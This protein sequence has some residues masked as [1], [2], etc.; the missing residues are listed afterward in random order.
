[1]DTNAKRDVAELDAR[2][3]AERYSLHAGVRHAKDRLDDGSSYNSEQLL[4][5]G[6]WTTANRK[7]N[8]R[9][10]HEQSFSKRDKNTDYPSRTTLGLD[11]QLNHRI[12]A[13]AE[14]ELTW[15]G[16]EDT[17]STRV[18]L[19]ATP[20]Q[21]GEVRSTI[22]RQ[23]NENGQRVFAIF[24]LGQ[25]WRIN[26]NWSMDA[27]LDRSY[28]V[29]SVDSYRFN[30]N[31]PPAQG[32][33][34][35]F[36]S[37]SIGS[38]Y[39]KEK[40]TWWNRLETRQADNEDKYGVSTSVVAEPQDGVALSAKAL[41]FISDVSNGVRRTDGNIRMGMAYRPAA[42]RWILLNRLDFYF[43]REDHSANE[44]DNWRIV[45]N[46]HANF[47][48]NR[49]LQMSFYY[50]LKYVR[51][52]YNGSTYSG[53]TDLIS[54]ETRYNINKRWDVGVHGSILHSWNSDTFEY[55]AGADIGYSPMTNTW[56]SLGYNVVG[57]EDEDFSAANYTAQG[58]YMRFRTKFDQQSVRDAAEWMNR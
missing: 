51:D 1:L 2:Y 14:Q 31:V 54:F 12:S 42:S 9:A 6:D 4:F 27:S 13:F 52:N 20:W 41:A 35:D 46:L 43:D 10:D 47:R 36:T 40:W 25:T 7:L 19:K 23:M 45:N 3:R 37:V 18:G 16:Q 11:Y 32:S 34:D 39:R 53:Y 30:D 26:Q 50:G 29:T 57:F 48:L 56:V 21:G 55:S 5:G 49:R 33:D 22:E 44:Y 58:A 17:E 38:T 8:V 15:G 28:T 24:G